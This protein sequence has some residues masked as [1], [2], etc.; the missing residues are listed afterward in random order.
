MSSETSTNFEETTDHP[1]GERNNDRQDVASSKSDLGDDSNIDF[2][3]LDLFN[4]PDPEDTSPESFAEELV[5]A[6]VAA[7]VSDLF[8]SDDVTETIVRCKLLGCVQDVVRL[9][10]EFG[11]RLSNHFQAFSGVDLADRNHPGQGRYL[12][13]TDE[14]HKIEVRVSVIPSLNGQDVSLR[15]FDS[16]LGELTLNDLGMPNIERYKLQNLLEHTGGLILIAGPTGSGKTTTQ[17]ASLRYLN[18]GDRKI[19][20]LEE[21]V[22]FAIPGIVQSQVNLRMNLDFAELLYHCLRHSPDVIMIGEI[23]DQ[24]TAETAVRAA[25]S[26]VLVIATVHASDSIGAIRSMTAYGA[27]PH[28]LG[29]SL[30]GVVAQ[31]LMRCLCS[32]CKGHFSFDSNQD[33]YLDGVDIDA[34]PGVYYPVGCEA[35]RHTGYDRRV[36]VAE[37]LEI[38]DQ[39]RHAI[40][41]SASPSDLERL[42]MESGMKPLDRA[43][44]QRLHGGETTI[45]EIHRTYRKRR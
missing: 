24:R 35:C 4:L 2:E 39:L 19:H 45:E 31:R 43:V 10:R 17:Y 1:G 33:G 34:M 36:C 15:L 6:A 23:R 9:G 37:V 30:I 25:T 21:P 7:N 40:S 5:T 14:G 29:S 41:T 20:T 8:V 12:V 28:F 44:M 3:E 26:G 22:E 11:R 13:E 38:N 32:K 27:K 18:H 42:A 16:K